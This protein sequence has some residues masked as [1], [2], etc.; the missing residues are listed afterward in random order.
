MERFTA[1]TE[2][3]SEESAGLPRPPSIC[4]CGKDVA[5]TLANIRHIRRHNSDRRPLSEVATWKTTQTGKVIWSSITIKPDYEFY[6]WHAVCSECFYG[7][8]NQSVQVYTDNQ[9]RIAWTWF[10]AVMTKD[11]E[12]PMFQKRLKDVT[13]E[14]EQRWLEIVNREAHRT[15][16]PD[17]IPAEYRIQE[18]WHR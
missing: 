11:T 18:I 14:Q 16:N 13:E 17:A 2:E 4:G 5:V 7:R 12:L 6:G 3:T 8:P 9:A 10:L 15:G 1:P